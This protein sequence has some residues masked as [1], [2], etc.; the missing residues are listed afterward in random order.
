MA[1]IDI[2]KSFAN[3][4]EAIQ[5]VERGLKE[6]T[7]LLV[8]LSAHVSNLD[9]RVSQLE[10]LASDSAAAGGEKLSLLRL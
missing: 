6:V 7:Q 8:G 4:G 2:V 1:S 10:S 3:I 9:K 5:N